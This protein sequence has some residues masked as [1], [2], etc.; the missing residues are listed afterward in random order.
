MRTDVVV[1]ERQQL[2]V[3]SVTWQFLCG[4]FTLH[5]KK[6]R[7]SWPEFGH[8]A[9]NSFEAGEYATIGDLAA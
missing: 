5:G 8:A 7:S 6:H 2:D 4:V 3:P 1:V 9:C